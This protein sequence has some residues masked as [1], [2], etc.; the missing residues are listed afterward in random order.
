LHPDADGVDDCA[1]ASEASARSP[2]ANRKP[3]SYSVNSPDWEM[4]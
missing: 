2:E 4:L 1:A 3:M